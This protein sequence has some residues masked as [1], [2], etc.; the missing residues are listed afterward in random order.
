MK[1]IFTKDTSKRLNKLKRIFFENFKISF[2]SGASIFG[3]VL[4]QFLWVF[5]LRG[6]IRL[7]ALWIVELLNSPTLD[8]IMLT[9]F[10]WIMYGAWFFLNIL[11]R[12][13]KIKT[14]SEDKR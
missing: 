10:F 9:N 11:T 13:I 3:F 2:E 12:M 14:Y 6:F 5:L 4:V 1:P 7:F 8:I